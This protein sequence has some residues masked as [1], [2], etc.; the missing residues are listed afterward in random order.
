MQVIQ[1]I[2]W[3]FLF[4]KQIIVLTS[5]PV[6]GEKNGTKA[7]KEFQNPGQPPFCVLKIIS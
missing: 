6:T 7:P 2:R 4:F 1:F 5:P 3:I